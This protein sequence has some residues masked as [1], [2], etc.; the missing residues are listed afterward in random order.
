MAV[1]IFAPSTKI[2]TRASAHLDC[3]RGCAALTVYFAHIRLFFFPQYRD[4]AVHGILVDS[5]YL[6]TKLGH[7]AVMVFFVLSGYLVGGSVLK[8]MVAKRWNWTAYLLK[9]GTRLYIVLIPAL[10]LTLFW[11]HAI[12]HFPSA[13]A[14]HVGDIPV[15]VTTPIVANLGWPTFL[16]NLLFLQTIVSPPY[17]TNQPL[18]SLSWEWWYYLLFPCCLIAL[19]SVGNR[20]TIFGILAASIAVLVGWQIT[21][22]FIVWL[23]GAW[24]S[25]QPIRTRNHMF[26][27]F[28]LLL[29]ASLLVL[30]G[31]VEWLGVSLLVNILVDF[32]LGIGTSVLMLALISNIRPTVP[33]RLYSATAHHI[34]A[35]SYTLY[36]VHLP[37]ILFLQ[38]AFMPVPRPIGIASF[39]SILA[40]VVIGLLYS[41]A[42]WWLIE[43]RT[44]SVRIKIVELTKLTRSAERAA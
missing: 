19:R 6:I 15:G 11:D 25:V 2:S 5:F 38:A 3:L 36:V 40:I 34:S 1:D 20:R 4:L 43:S 21:S 42:L 7:A 27:P 12:L 44:D 22:Y 41:D 32:S 31:T 8:D 18:W 13:S 24:L 29:M 33:N 28:A 17:G 37:F 39:A 23:M 14:V 26:L 10:F 9:R 16:C 30:A 35:F